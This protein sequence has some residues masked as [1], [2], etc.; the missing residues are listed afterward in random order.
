[1]N[2]GII[3]KG[4]MGKDLFDFFLKVENRLTLICRKSEDIEILNNSIEGQL[5]KM[6][7]RGYIT[8][9]CYENKRNS[10]MVSDSITSL[11]DCDLVIE[12]VYEERELKQKLLQEVEKVVK[13]DCVLATNTSSIPLRIV[14]EKCENKNRCMG[15][16]F[17]YPN[18]ITKTVE[19]NKATFTDEIYINIAKEYLTNV[20]KKPIVLDEPLNMI[21]SKLILNLS[22]E[23]YRIYEEKYLTVAELD[24][25]VKN[26]LM[27]FGLFEIIDSTGLNIILTS[28]ENFINERYEK[29]YTPFRIAG[30]TLIEEGYPGGNCNKGFAEYE[31]DNVRI[32]N[33]MDET[34]LERYRQNVIL[35]L[36]S[37]IIN[38]LAY[39]IE[40]S[41]IDNNEINDAVQEVLGLSE[42]PISLLNRIGKE[43]LK[44]CL[45]S[46]LNM[47][48]DN[49]Y[50]PIDLSVLE[51]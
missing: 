26:K 12:S 11:K 51:G 44:K 13:P 2:I 31:K 39:I 46:S 20:G 22:A 50:C 36:Q 8:S 49:I 35:R 9:E 6:K 24:K 18:C 23:I 3:G 32:P 15:L 48:Q 14:F 21:M 17:F 19:I 28:L 30:R 45:L 5:K 1:M 38:E 37:L 7:R 41:N 29:L 10:Y 27:T 25:I 47:Y 34:E 16:H 43:N 42:S 33:K 40:T 4:K